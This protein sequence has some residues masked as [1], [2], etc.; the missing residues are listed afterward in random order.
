MRLSCLSANIERLTGFS[1]T[2]FFQHP[3]TAAER[4]HPD[5][6][7]RVREHLRRAA[8]DG[9]ELNLQY[10]W[11]HC[12]GQY[13]WIEDRATINRNPMTG[14]TELVGNWRDISQSKQ[15]ELRLSQAA[16]EPLALCH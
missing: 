15:D 1:A 11:L 3:A 12:D 6:Q 4:L 13:R 14:K 8:D 7:A 5:D 16:E 2:H 10:R 9:T